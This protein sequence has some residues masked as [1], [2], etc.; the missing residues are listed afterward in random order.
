[1]T[2][3][4]KNLLHERVTSVAFKPPD[5]QAISRAGGR[6][7]RRR[8]IVA[9]LATAA[10]VALA[11]SVATVVVGRG[12]EHP[13]PPLPA[14]PA[15]AVSWAFDTTIFVGTDAGIEEIEV[16]H[17]VSAYVRTAIGFVILDRTDAVYSVT[18]DGV[19]PIGQ[20]NDTL[21]DNTD[22]QRLV[23]NSS[24]TLVGWVDEKASPE[25][26]TV[27]IYDTVH[28]SIRDFPG[29]LT[30]PDVH[31]L[32]LFAIDNRTAYWRTYEGVHQVDVDTRSDR[33]IVAREDVSPGDAIY[34]FE[35]YSAEHGVLAFS[36]DDDR[37]VFVGQSVKD[38]IEVNNFREARD[39]RA[40]GRRG[41][42]HQ[43]SHRP[44]S[45]LADR[46]LAELRHVLCHSNVR[47]LPEGRRCRDQRS[48]AHAH[49]ARRRHRRTGR[50]GHP[51]PPGVGNPVGLARRQHSAGCVV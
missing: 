3:S 46:G 40:A 11:G 22:E 15:D 21:P 12:T 36:P 39:P 33:L 24:G 16:G 1:M 8:R 41:R 10:V 9:L 26:L 51:G 29:P 2:E 14:S 27:R 47:G 6:R 23:V 19:M 48:A 7:L 4:L 45:P 17:E 49:R 43:R 18:E 38:A 37:T 32:V 44:G 13:P 25:S 35:V 50:P 34:S 31:A 30:T 42:D 5:I 28:G 20:V